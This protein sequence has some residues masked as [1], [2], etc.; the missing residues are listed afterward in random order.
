MTFLDPKPHDQPQQQITPP[1]IEEVNILMLVGQVFNSK[2]EMRVGLRIFS[3][4]GD[5]TYVLPPEVAV[6]VFEKGYEVAKMTAAGILM[7]PTLPLQ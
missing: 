5:Q 4:L 6:Q 1:P 7:A 3:P 2:K